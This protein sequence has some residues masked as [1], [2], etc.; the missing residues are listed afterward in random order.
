MKLTKGNSRTQLRQNFF[1]NRASGQYVEQHAGG[2][3]DGSDGEIQCFKGR[4]DRHSAYNTYSMEWRYGPAESA[5]EA[6]FQ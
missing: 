4:F 3:G 1:S 2:C 5:F 6:I